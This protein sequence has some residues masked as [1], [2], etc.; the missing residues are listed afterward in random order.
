MISNGNDTR[1]SAP[2]A[3]IG[4]ASFCHRVDQLIGAAHEKQT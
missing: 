1:P 4:P 3:R 2:P